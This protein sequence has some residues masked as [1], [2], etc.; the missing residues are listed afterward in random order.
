MR[1][2]DAQHYLGDEKSALV[3]YQTALKLR[4]DLVA[5]DPKNVAW[6]RSLGFSCAKLGAA[7][8][9]TGERDK[10]LAMYQQALEVR[11]TLSETSPSHVGLR[12]ELASAQLALGRALQR[13][14]KTRAVKLVTQS[15]EISRGLVASDPH[16]N[17]WKE[18]CVS[19]LL[20]LA[21]I[22][23][24]DGDRPGERA[25][26][27]EAETIA[28]AALTAASQN[29]FW[30]AYLAEIHLTFA[31]LDLLETPPDQTSATE[32]FAAARALLEP[33]ERAKTLPASRKAML[34]R[35]QAGK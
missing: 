10:S 11:Q 1:R 34:Q 13:T 9:Q 17:E 5:R 23:H 18:T 20:V 22:A 28:Q 25:L 12:N 31:D 3:S 19:G 7:F 29:A 24:T 4:Q 16:N 6:R 21:R 26:L 15:L 30:P 2:G 33:L 27:R 14:D 32:H 8:A 35:A